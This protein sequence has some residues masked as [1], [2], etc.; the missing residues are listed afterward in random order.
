[1]QRIFLCKQA[2]SPI[3]A[4]IY[5]HLAMNT[6]KQMTQRAG[7]LRQVDYFALGSHYIDTGLITIDID[8]YT[9]EAISLTDKLRHIQASTD[10][11]ALR[12]AMNQI[13][14]EKKQTVACD[15]MN[16]LRQN[17]ITLNDAAWQ[18]IEGLDQPLIVKQLAEHEFLHEINEPIPLISQPSSV[19]NITVND[20]P[21]LLA[22]SHY[23][24]Y[25]IH[26]TVADIANAR[27][28][29]YSFEECAAK[30]SKTLHCVCNFAVVRDLE[31]EFE[32]QKIYGDVIKIMQTETVLAR[33]Y[34]RL[35]SFSYSSGR[36]DAPNIDTHISELGIIIGEQTW[37]ELA[38]T[39][40]VAD[41]LSKIRLE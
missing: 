35:K 22:L 25:T 29:Y 16:A 26:G 10:D 5:E 21:A 41:L 9:D 27:L 13:T 30:V 20:N 8:L 1:M 28:G 4:H 40:I 6:F 19:L 23:L 14:A 7:L 2:T 32:L 12:L 15:D 31:N 33:L 37:K 11:E 38:D 24:A 39:S 36:M 17:I 3:E 34:R 18:T